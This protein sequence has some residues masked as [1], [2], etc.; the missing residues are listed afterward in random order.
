MKFNPVLIFIIAIIV[1]ILPDYRIQILAQSKSEKNIRCAI[2][3]VVRDSLSGKPVEI[4][5]ITAIF[6]EDTAKVYGAV[7]AENGGFE[8]TNLHPGEYEVRISHLGYRTRRRRRVNLVPGSNNLDLGTVLLSQESITLD[9]ITVTASKPPVIFDINKVV[10]NPRLENG[11]NALEQLENA[12]FVNVN[13]DGQ[14]SIGGMNAIEIYIDGRPAAM[15]GIRQTD[16]LRSVFFSEIDRIEIITG[17]TPEFPDGSF[18]GIVNIVTKKGLSDKYSAHIGG[19]VTSKRNLYAD[20]DVSV[21]L[22]SLIVRGGY[23]NSYSRFS[24][25]SSVIKQYDLDNKSTLLEQV[26]NAERKNSSNNGN[27]NILFMPNEYSS[28]SNNVQ[29]SSSL[30]RNNSIEDGH[31]YESN[32]TYKKNVTGRNDNKS[33]NYLFSYS[34]MFKNKMTLDAGF[35]YSRGS[36]DFENNVQQSNFPTLQAESSA[37]TNT[38]LGDNNNTYS[39]DICGRFPL[40]SGLKMFLSLNNKYVLVKRNTSYLNSIEEYSPE[41]AGNPPE[42]NYRNNEGIVSIGLDGVLGKFNYSGSVSIMN[43]LMKNTIGLN[44]YEYNSIS[45]DPVLGLGMGIAQFSRVNLGYSYRSCNPSNEQISPFVI[46]TDSTNIILG[47]PQLKPYRIHNLTLNY[48]Q[49]LGESF[50]MISANY[51]NSIGIIEPITE[52]ITPFVTTTI[53]RNIGSSIRYETMLSGRTRIFNAL[54]LQPSVT[55]S[56]NKYKSAYTANESNSWF[57]S[58]SIGSSLRF[59]KVQMDLNYS[60]PTATAQSRYKA[61]FYCS[62]S[63]RGKL[64]DN[65]LNISLRV[66]DIFNSMQR[67]YDMNGRGISVKN[68]MHEVSRVFSLDV[69]YLFQSKASSEPSGKT[70]RPIDDF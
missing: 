48:N 56:K 58:L 39:T 14:M 51:Y 15:Y 53:N 10:L 42:V 54:D 33:F 6:L 60:S 8:L 16:D 22:K 9:D 44:N 32:S 25:S 36:T 17:P 46:N 66:R 20:T 26:F 24:Q 63:V 1:I 65:N 18:K 7:S 29:Y 37:A 12:P 2:K 50:F 49:M 69:S 31:Y 61:L 23:R 59:L 27:I 41:S 35:S 57:S 40:S 21:S 43:Y 70:A 30:G 45:I 28:L 55:Y 62:A 13:F 38:L 11:N 47:N 67:N 3:G 64:F 5:N 34:G 52:L 68:T 19:G 4:A